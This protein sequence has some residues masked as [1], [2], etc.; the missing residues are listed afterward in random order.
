MK[1]PA[2]DYPTP[3]LP[4]AGYR[5]GF[6]RSMDGYLTL[7]RAIPRGAAEEIAYRMG[8]VT[9][10]TVRAWCREPASDDDAA[11]GRR[12][13]LDRVCDLI[14]A[15]FELEENGEENA[16]LIVDH[17]RDYL[18]YLKAKRERKTLPAAELEAKLQSAQML[19]SEISNDLRA[20]RRDKKNNK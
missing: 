17:V 11:T 4:D 8:G 10:W 1:Q 18:D 2:P 9:A 13:P 3:N 6:K 19:I 20:R 5:K 12:S 15:V 14:D 16:E 7:Q